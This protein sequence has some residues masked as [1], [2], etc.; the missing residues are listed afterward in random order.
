MISNPETLKKAYAECR[1]FT[2]AHGENF[3]VVFFTLKPH[4]RNHL[5]SIYTFARTADDI[6]DNE[7]LPLAE[8]QMQLAAIR[9]DLIDCY[10]GKPNNNAFLALADTVQACQIPIE[11]LADLL[12][13]FEMDLTVNRYQTLEQ[14]KHY[15]KY[16]AVPVG[17]IVLKIFN[18]NDE[19]WVACSDAICTALQLINFWQDVGVDLEKDRIYL[20]SAEFKQHGVTEQDI[21]TRHYSPAFVKLMESVAQQTETLLDQG[22]PLLNIPNPRLRMYFR[23][24]FFSAKTLLRKLAAH[25]FPVLERKITLSKFDKVKAL[26]RVF[27]YRGSRK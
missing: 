23:M 6:A 15:S 3:P 19:K 16:S 25:H 8:R 21:L 5:A 22:K 27:L 24:T 12:T 4:E 7:L 18:E 1:A 17:R 11:L 13:A 2:R 10:A 20:P 9:A 14:L 26:R